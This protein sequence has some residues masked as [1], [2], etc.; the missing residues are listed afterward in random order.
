MLAINALELIEEWSVKPGRKLVDRKLL[1][2]QIGDATQTWHGEKGDIEETASRFRR[3]IATRLTRMVLKWN[4]PERTDQERLLAKTVEERI[5]E[6]RK[7]VAKDT[8]SEAEEKFLA[9]LDAD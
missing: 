8:A 9:M 6:I 1:L 2:Q 4:A 7:R 5:A 3:T